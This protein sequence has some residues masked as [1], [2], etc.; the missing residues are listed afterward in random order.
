MSIGFILPSKGRPRKLEKSIISIKE[1]TKYINYCVYIYVDLDD[2][3]I[4]QYKKIFSRYKGIVHGVVGEK[5][6]VPGAF[7]LLASMVREKYIMMFND[8]LNISTPN[9]DDIFLKKISVIKDEIFLAYF[10]DGINFE[11]HAAFPIIPKKK[12][13]DVVGY[14]S[15]KLIFQHNDTWVFSI[16]VMLHRCVYFSN[17]K[18]K[19]D[20]GYLKEK[21]KDETFKFNRN[22]LKIFLDHL[23]FLYLIFLRINSYLKIKKNLIE[24]ENSVQ[25]ENISKFKVE[26]K[27][28]FETIILFFKLFS[29]K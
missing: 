12:W 13:Y 17:I 16:G 1:K 2:K 18:L 28:F 23:I 24:I 26:L 6:G 15:N 29:L 8:D 9:W 5:I 19:H 11:R 21:Y 14:S 27:N 20:H 3:Y 25:F 7:N 4:N 22:K 10:N